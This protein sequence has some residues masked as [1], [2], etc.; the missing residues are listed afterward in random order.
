MI[1]PKLDKC[2]SGLQWMMT[3][4]YAANETNENLAFR[5]T[6]CCCLQ[7]RSSRSCR[8]GCGGQFAGS[9]SADPRERLSRASTTGWWLQTCIIKTNKNSQPESPSGQ[10]SELLY[11]FCTFKT[12]SYTSLQKTCFILQVYNKRMQK[13]STREANRGLS[14]ENHQTPSYTT[15]F[16]NTNLF[17]TKITPSRGKMKT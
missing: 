6:W 15:M 17:L 7:R 10:L 16:H 4:T 1:F 3:T 8:R 5:K 2:H 13:S 14:E 12:G 11:I 9:C